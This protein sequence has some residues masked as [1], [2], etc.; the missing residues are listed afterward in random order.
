MEAIGGDDTAGA[1]MG[2]T[3]AGSP[4]TGLPVFGHEPL[5]GWANGKLEPNG[6]LII[7]AVFR[8]AFPDGFMRVRSRGDQC[9]VAYSLRAFDV[10]VDDV[11]RR[12]GGP[13]VDPRLRQ[14]AYSSAHKVAID[15][16]SRVV[17][18]AEA[19]DDVALGEE[20]VFSGQVEALHIYPAKVFHQEV[21]SRFGDFDL[22][23]DSHSGLPTDPA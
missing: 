17:I 13:G 23:L 4:S 3:S 22:M 16:Q 20:I 21:K 6:R 18:P 19:R 5:S 7:P 15:R 12:N 1:A 11:I 9:L 8:Y 10:L 2:L 14:S